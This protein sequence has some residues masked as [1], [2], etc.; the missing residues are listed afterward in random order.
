MTSFSEIG[1]SFPSDGESTDGVA[2]TDA[3]RHVNHQNSS[4][5]SNSEQIKE[6]HMIANLSFV[7]FR[8]ATIA[9][10]FTHAYRSL[11]LI[12]FLYPDNDL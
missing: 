3:S 11:G 9:Q 8:C 10:G 4:L 6:T 7:P 12:Q 1:V 5:F 2:G